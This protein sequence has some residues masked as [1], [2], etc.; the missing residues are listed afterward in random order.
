MARRV[1][2]R[3]AEGTCGVCGTGTRRWWG[4][5]RGGPPDHTPAQRSPTDQ[6][7]PRPQGQSQD[8][9]ATCAAWPLH[10]RCQELWVT[11]NSMWSVPYRGLWLSREKGHT[12]QNR[13]DTNTGEKGHK[14]TK[15]QTKTEDHWEA[16]E[17]GESGQQDELFQKPQDA[18]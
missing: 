12:P 16:G 8:P 18:D 15:A 4:G 11:E 3:R 5:R 9:S 14:Q 10:T 6:R 17:K 13:A 1:P 2:A 7:G